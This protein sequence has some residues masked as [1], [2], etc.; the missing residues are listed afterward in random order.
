MALKEVVKGFVFKAVT[1]N[2]IIPEA[3]RCLE[4]DPGGTQGWSGHDDDDRSG[5]DDRNSQHPLK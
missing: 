3:R 4:W 5:G 1:V 2:L